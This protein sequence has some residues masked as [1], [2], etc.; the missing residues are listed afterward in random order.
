MAKANYRSI[1]SD[2]SDFKSEVGSPYLDQYEYDFDEKGEVKRTTLHKT[3]KPVNVHARIQADFESCDI[4]AIMRRFALGDT[5][6]V[7]VREGV[8]ADVTKMP[9]TFAELFDRINDCQTL[10]NELDPE[11]K[12]LFNNS[13]EEFWYEMTSDE[14]SFNSKIDDYNDRFIDHEFDAVDPEP[15]DP[16]G[17]EVV[18]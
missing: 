5:S 17:G 13:Y 2:T 6:A 11:L 15:V 1:L 8:Y 10:F 4:N 7:N 12:Q 18:E 9:K 3:D 16:K 14:K